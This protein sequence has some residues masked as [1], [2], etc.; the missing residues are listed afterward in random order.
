VPRVSVIVAARDAAA[1]LP[2]TLASVAAQTF[3]DWEVVLVDDGSTDET[4]ELARS[5]PGRLR[6]LRNEVAQGPS[7]ARNTAAEHADGEL[8]A[9]LDADDMWQP[10]YLERQLARYDAATAAG[11]RI[12]LITCNAALLG[13]RGPLPDT[14]YERVGYRSPVTL[15]T[16][17]HNNVL[18]SMA[19]CP[20][21]VFVEA[22][23][24]DPNLRHGE[25]YDLWLRILELGYEV[26]G[27]DDV[28]ATYRFRA[29]A[30]SVDTVR[31]SEGTARVYELALQRGHLDAHERR[32]ARRQRRLQRAVAG[33]ARLAAGDGGGPIGRLRLLPLAAL[34]ALEH[35]DRWIGWLRGGARDAG[36]SR[37]A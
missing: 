16:L 22:G 23:A 26:I 13:P 18:P 15:A 28:L 32:I 37:H 24:Y 29:G 12:G 11:R 21:T 10:G 9:M 4:A 7:A 8:L 14:Y 3:A 17:L 34:V 31:L 5:F 6:L 1:T 25:D 36:P 19:T 30:A 20:R 35:P 27:D 2:D 33:R